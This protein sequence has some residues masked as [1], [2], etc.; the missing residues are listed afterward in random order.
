MEF[1]CRIFFY[2]KLEFALRFVL[3]YNKSNSKGENGGNIMKQDITKF[4]IRPIVLSVLSVC[5]MSMMM[6]LSACYDSGV[7]N[8]NNWLMNIII[9]IIYHPSETMVALYYV[10]IWKVCKLCLFFGLGILLACTFIASM[11]VN[12]I[13]R[14]VIFYSSLITLLCT[15]MLF[16]GWQECITIF[17]SIPPIEVAL[18]GLVMTI[19]FI[20]VVIVRLVYIR[21][22]CYKGDKASL[23]YKAKAMSYNSER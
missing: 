7:I 9:D 6:Y 2:Q 5:W 1:H 12:H 19:G 21:W 22:L 11:V 16:D 4:E 3:F 20:G 13:I 15:M 18:Y 14:K 17:Q 8:T 10:K 23:I